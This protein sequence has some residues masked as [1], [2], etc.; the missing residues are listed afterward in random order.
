MYQDR[1]FVVPMTTKLM[2]QISVLYDWLVAKKEENY[3]YR[4]HVGA[5]AMFECGW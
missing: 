5:L 1:S 3:N 2:D 4:E